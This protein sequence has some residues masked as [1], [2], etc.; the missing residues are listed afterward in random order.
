MGERLGNIIN[1]MKL[2]DPT[3]QEMLT[4]LRS[5]FH[6]WGLEGEDDFKFAIHRFASEWYL[7]QG[8]NLYKAICEL[9]IV[10]NGVPDEEMVGEMVSVLETHFGGR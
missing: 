10:D 7:G 4:V 3:L 1:A 5:E 8:S 9:D 2:T 6:H